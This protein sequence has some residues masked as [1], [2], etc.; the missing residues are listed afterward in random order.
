MTDKDST[1]QIEDNKLNQFNKNFDEYIKKKYKP[2]DSVNRTLS[3]IIPVFISF[4]S[5]YVLLIECICNT[6]ISLINDNDVCKQLGQKLFLCYMEAY[7]FFWG[8]TYFCQNLI[9]DQGKNM[10]GSCID[11]L[12]NK[13]RKIIINLNEVLINNSDDIINQ[14]FR[15]IKKSY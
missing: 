13:T 1:F 2:S 12:G 11:D 9:N 8:T 4:V 7:E 15:D 5:A 14:K 3:F 10:I 6:I